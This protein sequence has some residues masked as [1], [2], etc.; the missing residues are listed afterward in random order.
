MKRLSIILILAFA[1][2]SLMAGDTGP[3]LVVR[4][5]ENGVKKVNI[6]LPIEVALAFAKSIEIDEEHLPSFN[7][8]DDS[9]N[10]DGH[11]I[12]LHEIIASLDTFDGSLVE[13]NDPESNTTINV[14]VSQADKMLYVKVNGE[15]NEKVDVKIPLGLIAELDQFQDRKFQPYELLEVIVK[16]LTAENLPFTFVHVQA[17]DADVL[18]EIK[19]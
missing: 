18:V 2:L 12:N 8:G 16:H 10:F 11:H 9:L 13:I 1:S 6:N 5:I 19:P 7:S 14:N 3:T 17:D 15:N 4:V